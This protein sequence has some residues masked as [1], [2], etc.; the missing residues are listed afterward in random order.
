[1]D[2]E[3]RL[4]VR[5][6]ANSAD[7]VT[8]TSVRGGTNPYLTSTPSGDAL[9]VDPRNAESFL[10]VYSIR[11]ADP[12]IGSMQRLFTSQLDDANGRPQL[13]FRVAI[14]EYRINGGSWL[15]LIAGIIV[16]YRLVSG[17][18]WE[19][20]VGDPTHAGL[21]TQ[22]FAPTSDYLISDFLDDWP[23][24]GCLLGGPVMGASQGAFGIADLGGWQMRVE[25]TAISGEYFLRPISIYGPPDWHAGQ[26]NQTELEAI[27]QAINDAAGAVQIPLSDGRASTWDTIEDSESHAWAWRGLVVLID[28]VAWKPLAPDYDRYVDTNGNVVQAPR[29]MNYGYGGNAGLKVKSDGVKT[30][31]NG[32]L[33]RVRA[34]TVLPSEI[35]PLYLVDHP[36][37]LLKRFWGAVGRSYNGTAATAL[38]ELI[39]TDARFAIRITSAKVL[40]DLEK[41][42]C[43]V[44]GIG[45]RGNDSGELVVFDARLGR[46]TTTPAVTITSADV[47]TGTFRPYDLDPAQAV[48]S[49]AFSAKRFADQRTISADRRNQSI[50]DGVSVSDLEL[51]VV[52]DAP[53]ALPYGDIEMAFDGMILG[54]SVNYPTV[55]DFFLAVAWRI[56][57]RWGWGGIGASMTLLRGGAGDSVREGDEILV[58]LDE[59]PNLNYRLGDNPSIAARAMQIIRRTVVA[60]GYEVELVDSGLTG[61]PPGTLPTVT[62]AASSDLPRT[63]AEVTITNAATLNAAGYGAELQLAFGATSTRYTSVLA[64]GPG[65]IPTGA[66][67]LPPAVAG[68][69]I[70]V[71]ARSTQPG[72]RPSN[73]GTPANAALTGI[74]AP[75]AFSATPVG[76]DGSKCDLAWTNGSATDLVDIWIRF[77]GQSFSE[78]VRVN[79]L[80]PG[81]NRYQLTGL[82]P[83]TDYIAT[84][85]HRDP[86]TAD[87][88]S[89][90]DATFTTSGTGVTLDP[91]TY[92][93]PFAFAPSLNRLL[94]QSSLKSGLYGIGVIAAHYPGE[95]EIAEAV[96]TAVGAGTY[97]S[98][99]TVGR[100]PSVSGNWTL[101]Q[102]YAPNDGLRRKLK[103]RHVGDGTTPSSY[104]SEVVVTPWTYQALPA[105]PGDALVDARAVVTALYVSA[106]DYGA[107][108]VTV[109]WV[110]DG[111]LGTGTFVVYRIA[112]SGATADLSG[113]QTNVGTTSGASP[114]SIV[115]N[116]PDDIISTA[117]PKVT[118]SYQVRVYD[119]FG[120]LLRVSEWMNVTYSHA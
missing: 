69:A 59:T 68:S 105:Y 1:V 93:S 27:G 42:I 22:M 109:T 64:W 17:I 83:G 80:P 3:Y 50:V 43:F 100:I 30:L 107:N 67:R 7:V 102:S 77:D 92:P 94:G 52:N 20:T 34:L 56:F 106:V 61:Q 35:S 60:E 70:Y 76:A 98:Y 39:G 49:I 73:W 79:T 31:T 53:G 95:I 119:S 25:T 6:V 110:Y 12:E 86:R 66:I 72:H 40:S 89:E 62:I 45:I 75:S 24:R 114:A 58:D 57:D 65:K 33:V 14:I 113:S 118:Y 10:G 2:I 99:S 37:E 46:A 81:S 28:G 90:V 63:V 116:V 44:W 41:L 51:T 19:V 117:G 55:R 88:S 47:I 4:R 23:M 38:K 104:S 74:T 9:T 21:V 5:N 71:R 103:A 18:E 87:A 91:P 112:T 15:V 54:G 36:V 8:I 82:E 97:G 108:Q 84:V 85:Q 96:E 48:K 29:L 16:R 26:K 32:A 13:G 120:T 101:W 115:D 111:S 78:A 11:F